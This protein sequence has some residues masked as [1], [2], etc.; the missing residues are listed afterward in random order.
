MTER[1]PAM[2]G[3][4]DESY[5]SARRADAL[6]ALCSA[7]VTDDADPDQATVVVHA[8]LESLKRGVGGCE[9]E[10]GPVLHPQSVRRMLCNAWV[11]TLIEDETG[12]VVGLG[13]MSRQPSAWM[14]RQVRYRD[15]ECRF[16]R[17]GA[18]RFT[19]A[20]HIVWWRFGGR[21]DLDN[22]LVHEFGW[23]VKRHPDGEVSWLRPDGTRYRAGP[24]P[25]VDAHVPLADTG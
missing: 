2:P 12:R 19:E 15:R 4:E 18:R 5:A 23:S 6:A 24:Q 1:V 25:L 14:V 9:A 3:E 10:A 8:Q 17:C 20:H 7:S 21:T 11:Q 16:P 13:R 22:R